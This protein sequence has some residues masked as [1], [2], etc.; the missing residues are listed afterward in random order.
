M[1]N[2]ENKLKTSKIR[3]LN[4][5]CFIRSITGMVAIGLIC[6]SLGCKIPNEPCTLNSCEVC[7]CED[8]KCCKCEVCKCCKC[9][10]CKC[11][12]CKCCKCEVCKCEDCK[13]C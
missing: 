10:V 2:L 8:C 7:K 6:F 12:D 3:S 1:D 9:E 13:C 5:K 4:M 11:E